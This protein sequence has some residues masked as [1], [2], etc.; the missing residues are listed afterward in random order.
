MRKILVI[1][2][3]ALLDVTIQIFKFF[4]DFSACL[5]VAACILFLV[6]MVI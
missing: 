6:K 5:N 3:V 4:N 1:N 2:F